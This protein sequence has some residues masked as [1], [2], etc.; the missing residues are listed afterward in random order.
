MTTGLGVAP[1]ARFGAPALRA[2]AFAPDFFALDRA[3]RFDARAGV[4]LRLA[5]FAMIENVLP[6]SL[7]VP[8]LK[9]L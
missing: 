2:E 5:D 1:R 8:L 3:G 7:S 9:L 6:R 4:R